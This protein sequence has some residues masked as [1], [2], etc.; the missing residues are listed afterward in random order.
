MN[1]YERLLDRA[2]GLGWK[3]WLFGVG[4]GFAPPK[5]SK[6]D[7]ITKKMLRLHCEQGVLWMTEPGGPIM[8]Q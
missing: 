3:P 4:V 7:L 8:Q 6:C 5:Q 2:Q 1:D